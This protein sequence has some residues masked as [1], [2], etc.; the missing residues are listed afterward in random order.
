[1]EFVLGIVIIVILLLILGFGI[2]VIIFGFIVLITLATASSALFFVYF[3]VRLLISKK[4]QG[5][6][7]RVAKQEKWKYESA[8]YDIGDEELPNVFPAEFVMR[9]KIY[10]TDRTVKLR[11]DRRGKFVYD[12]NARMTIL[13]GLPLCSALCGLCMMFFPYV[14]PVIG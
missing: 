11:L 7:T 4:T 6:F 3:T 9:D 14:V 13:F 10:H 1:M 2:D 8:F 12:R 5:T